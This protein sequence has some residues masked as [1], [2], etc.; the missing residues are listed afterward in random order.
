MLAGLLLALLGS[1]AGASESV[2]QGTGPWSLTA[3]AGKE[4]DARF[5]DIL[6]A[7]ESE[8]GSSKIAGL[9]LGYRLDRD[10]FDIIWAND[11][12]TWELEGQLYRHSGS[13]D[14]WEA[15]AALVVH[16]NEFPWHDTLPTTFSFAQGLSLASERPPIEEDTRRLLHYMH[17]EFTVRGPNWEHLSVVARLHHRSG[18]FGLYGTSGGSNFLTAGLRYR[19]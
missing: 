9:V 19:F 5:A 1:T 6:T 2:Y 12:L 7:Q 8:V 13:Q 16:W 15:N 11:A 10:R 14:H 4:D 18:A 3:L 17:A